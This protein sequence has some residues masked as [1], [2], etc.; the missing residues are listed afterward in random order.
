MAY[1]KNER[2]V[3]EFKI[4]F[5]KFNGYFYADVFLASGGYCIEQH[6][7]KDEIKAEEKALA[8]IKEKHSGAYGKIF[9]NEATDVDMLDLLKQSAKKEPF[10]IQVPR[11]EKAKEVVAK[12]SA[13]THDLALKAL[14]D[15][16]VDSVAIVYVKH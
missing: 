14:E 12:V 8:W 16:D 15:D 1:N 4:K 13:M 2:I 7:D 5:H 6:K 9:N 3:E 11:G 10:I